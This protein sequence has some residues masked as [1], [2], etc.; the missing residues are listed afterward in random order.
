MEH[1]GVIERFSQTPFA[2]S[3]VVIGIS[4]VISVAASSTAPVGHIILIANRIVVEPGGRCGRARAHF[5]G[6]FA[7]VFVVAILRPDASENRNETNA[8]RDIK[9][10]G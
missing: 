7:K 3:L 4:C 9:G 5:G 2:V 1:G 6:D 8:L 10:C